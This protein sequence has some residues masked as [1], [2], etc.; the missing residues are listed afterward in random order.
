MVQS[1]LDGLFEMPCYLWVEFARGNPIL[2]HE[3]CVFGQTEAPTTFIFEPD[4]NQ[5]QGTLV[6]PNLLV[7]GATVGC[8]PQ[9]L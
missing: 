4:L 2:G 8:L 3:V 5:G 7:C 6:Y 9:N 1:M